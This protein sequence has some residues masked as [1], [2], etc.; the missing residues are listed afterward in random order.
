MKRLVLTF[1]ALVTIAAVYAQ[2]LVGN[3]PA[4]VAVGEQFRLTYTINT[5][6]VS[7]FR[8][9]NIPDDLEVLMGPRQSSQSSFQM[10]N[11]HTS[12]S[13]SI[14]YTYI[15]LANKAGSYTIPPAQISYNGK[16]LHSNALHIKVSGSAQGNH[17]SQQSRGGN[18]NDDYEIRS[19]GSRISGSDLFIK[20]SANKKRIHEQ[21]PVLL[22]YKV[23]T[24][25]GLTQLRGEMPD[26]KGFHSQEIPLPREKSFHIETLNGRPYKTV[27][28]Q[29]WVVF[30]QMTGKLDIP[31]ITFEGMVVQQNR[32]VDPFEAFFNGGSGYVEVKKKIVAPGLTLQVDP[33]PTRPAG[34]SGGVGKFNIT[35]Q[36]NKTEVKANDPISLRVIVSGNGNLKL[37]K[38][39]V[40]NFPKDFDKYDAKVTDKTKITANGV[41]GSMVYDFMA[42]PRHQGTF[43]IPPVEFT[44]YDTQ[45]N[46]YKTLKSEGFKLQVAKGSG[47]GSVSDYSEEVEQLNK[48]IRFIKTGNAELRRTD[49]FFFGSASYWT[50]LAVMLIAFSSLFVV[51]R[52]RAID[53]ANLGKMR[54]KKANKVATRRL[55]A[56]NKLMLQNRSDEFYDEVLRALWGY[57]GDKLNM[58]VE[59]LSRENIQQQLA[60]H[61]V[62]EE[63]ISK[64]ITAIDEC[65]FERYAPGDAKGNMSK[66]FDAAMT[67]I[68]DIEEKMKK[69]KKKSSAMK[70][71]I[72]FA[73]LSLAF[74]TD[75]SAMATK[76]NA[77]Q[78]YK[79]EQYQQAIAD[80]EE[81]LK[82]GANA[83]IYYNLGNAYYRTNNITRAIINYERAALMSPG[84]ADV[85]F[86]LQLA[87]SK[88]ID[89]ITPEAEMFFFDWYRQVVNIM[90]VDGWATNALIA[91]AIAI[92]CALS[93]LFAERLILRKIGFFGA[94]AMFAIFILSNV[95]AVQQK[96]KLVNRTGAIITAP[97]VQIKST[98]SK[99]GTDIFN[100]H[101]GTRV[102]IIDASMKNWKEIR[103]ADGKRG[104]IE[105]SK[106][107][108][109]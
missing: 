3:A 40:V 47:S 86:N 68:M 93:Y 1:F 59:S 46:A 98:P 24:L 84:D 79:K 74:T 64:F 51:F 44:Y 35:A 57:V 58:P 49:E 32:D 30:P 73:F 18:S 45:A 67:A 22:T 39:P 9:G 95:M 37:I 52:Q 28:W 42:V 17:G 14:T 90:S 105:T 101:E 41:E 55:H 71:L 76:A 92:A 81:L 54:G 107:E 29:Q 10:I 96:D 53:N 87:R 33:L 100:L 11:G 63:T 25:V 70:A 23:Y 109:I 69:K 106:M 15:V 43:E 38:E 62:N 34:F 75:A 102:D 77:D 72:A 88:T 108:I 91:L 97:A 7:G 104:W 99:N 13:S 65:E 19:A 66:T 27:T 5:Q 56:A 8:A 21:E 12:S 83:D 26:M 60:G 6:D 94:L 2:K 103:I 36:I 16:T 78:A 80:Y 31:S 82:Q 85:R 48:D 50:M 61:D 89:K 4:Q 20:V